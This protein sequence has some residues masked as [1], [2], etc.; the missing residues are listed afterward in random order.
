MARRLVL[1]GE[2]EEVLDVR[3]LRRDEVIHQG[4]EV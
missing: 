4:D 1:L 3:Y 2:D